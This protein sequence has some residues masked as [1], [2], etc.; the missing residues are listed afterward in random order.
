M[1]TPSPMQKPQSTRDFER[2]LK[3]EIS[4]LDYWESLRREAE[5]DVERLRR[6]GRAATRA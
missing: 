2:L 3:R 1:G 4:A 6:G 5:A